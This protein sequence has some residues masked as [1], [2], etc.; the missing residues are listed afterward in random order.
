MYDRYCSANICHSFPSVKR[1]AIQKLVSGQTELSRTRAGVMLTLEDMSSMFDPFP[2]SPN[3]FTSIV[4]IS[5]FADVF[6]FKKNM[7][8]KTCNAQTFMPRVKFSVNIK[9]N[10]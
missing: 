4:N 8:A 3:Q 9:A 1:T 7:F 5:L 10:L 6:F 2:I